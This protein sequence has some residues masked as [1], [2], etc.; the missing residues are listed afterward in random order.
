MET[1]RTAWKIN[2]WCER[3]NR[4]RNTA[5]RLLARGELKAVKAGTNTLITAESDE[6]WWKSLP[7]Y[8]PQRSVAQ[9]DTR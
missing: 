9:E 5:Y 6:Q 3:R 2:E 8:R 1:E 7:E 4:S